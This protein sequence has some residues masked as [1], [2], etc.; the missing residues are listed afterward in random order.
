MDRFLSRTNRLFCAAAALLLLAGT[1]GCTLFATGMWVLNPNDVDAEYDGLREQRVVVV[2]RQ[3]NNLEYR[4]SGVAK[5]LS[6]AVSRKL[7]DNVKKITVVS[8]TE[9]DD[10]LD[11]NELDS[12]VEVGKALD[13]D[14]VVAIDLDNFSLFQ[15]TT[16]YQGQASA[17]IAVYDVATGDV[18]FERNPLDTLYPPTN[19]IPRETTVSE[20][21]F[22]RVFVSVLSDQIARTFYAYDSRQ[23]N[24]TDV[25]FVQ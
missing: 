18:V 20:A 2:C 7:R 5:Q 8:Q 4:N 6:S 19:P 16:L 24:K 12:Y 21:A 13:A 10:W 17:D 1:T 3:T 9:V 14:M 11:N 22:R 25:Y 23:A 15:G